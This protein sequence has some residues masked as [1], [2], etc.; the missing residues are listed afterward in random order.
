MCLSYVALS[1]AGMTERCYND[2]ELTGTS[3][4]LILSA[5]RGQGPL[6]TLCVVVRY[7]SRIKLRARGMIR[8]YGGAARL[9]VRYANAIILAPGVSMQILKKVANSGV[10][11]AIAVR[12]EGTMTSNKAYNNR[13]KM[14]LM[15][16][17]NEDS[18]GWLIM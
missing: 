13:G 9:V 11:Y 4:V 17:C 8:A 18:G 1:S 12:R 3:G 15:I 2:G 14:E 16:T 7:Y 6:Y 10:I 5:I